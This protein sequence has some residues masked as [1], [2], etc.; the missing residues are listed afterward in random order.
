M[1]FF[2]PRLLSSLCLSCSR[3]VFILH[4]KNHSICPQNESATGRQ[5]EGGFLSRFERL[6]GCHKKE[7]LSYCAHFSLFPA[8]VRAAVKCMPLSD[9][10][11]T[12]LSVIKSFVCHFLLCGTNCVKSRVFIWEKKSHLIWVRVT[13][14]LLLTFSA[15]T[16]VKTN[17]MPPLYENLH[18]YT[19]TLEMPKDSR[20][21]RL[22][23]NSL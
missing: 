11:L 8:G 22:L 19:G 18:K 14:S 9:S 23:D 15:K 6:I 12:C 20:T 1:G 21:H 7:L 5:R 13:V 3:K 4:E 2:S 17:K 16:R 10:Y